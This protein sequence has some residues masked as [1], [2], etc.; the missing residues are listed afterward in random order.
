MQQLN[1]LRHYYLMLFAYFCFTRALP[2]FLRAMLPAHMAWLVPAADQ[3]MAL[4]FYTFTAIRCRPHE[5][6][7]YMK[8]FTQADME[9]EGSA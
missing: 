7:V 8:L 2:S 4:A 1:I 6:N 3:L 5:S 9:A